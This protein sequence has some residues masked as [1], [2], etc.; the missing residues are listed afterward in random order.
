MIK[1]TLQIVIL[2]GVCG[3]AFLLYIHYVQQVLRFLLHV[4]IVHVI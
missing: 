1:A 3:F 2:I 4:Y